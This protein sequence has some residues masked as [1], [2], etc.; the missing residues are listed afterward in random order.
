[1]QP[2]T[3][4][5]LESILQGYDQPFGDSAAIPTYLLSRVARRHVKVALSGD[6]GDE[7]F[8]GYE[9]YRLML[10]AGSLPE[11]KWL[12]RG[13]GKIF[14]GAVAHQCQLAAF[15]ADR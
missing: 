1:M 13:L 10:L 15:W 3:F 2:P 6:G 5:E 4:Q 9:R 8:G 11:A 12:Q 7:V 14:L